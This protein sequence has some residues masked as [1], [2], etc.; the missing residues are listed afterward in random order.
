M[1]ELKIS[2]WIQKTIREKDKS[3]LAVLLMLLL[4][5]VGILLSGKGLF[6]L[7]KTED[8]DAVNASGGVRSVAAV[9]DTI[10]AADAE[11]RYVRELES[12]LAQSFSQIAGVGETQVMITLS[13]GREIELAQDVT[14][15]ASGTNETDAQGGRREQWTK[16]EDRKALGG[17]VVLKETVP[18]IQGVIIIAEGGGDVLVQDVLIRAAQAV[19]GLEANK[20][21]VFKKKS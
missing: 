11:T 21:C 19:L 20:I 10:S 16:N 9:A 18:K 4:A 15:S 5:G 8:K 7:A 14:T 13:N 6:N 12:R 3:V 2:E 1:K 17:P